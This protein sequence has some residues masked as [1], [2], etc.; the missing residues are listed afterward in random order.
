MN[1]PCA[2]HGAHPQEDGLGLFGE[3]VRYQRLSEVSEIKHRT[4][5]QPTERML[6][7]KSVWAI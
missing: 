6:D 3:Y 7:C 4:S 2:S 5:R 1:N